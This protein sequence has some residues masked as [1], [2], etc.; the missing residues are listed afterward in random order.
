[1]KRCGIILP[2]GREAFSSR[3]RRFRPSRRSSITGA[4]SRCSYCRFRIRIRYCSHYVP[5]RRSSIT[6]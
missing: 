1:M 2:P 5:S 6:G 3:S 4:E